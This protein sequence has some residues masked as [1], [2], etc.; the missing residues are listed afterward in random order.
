M[1]TFSDGSK[2]PV[3]NAIKAADVLYKKYFKF[4]NSAIYQQ[5]ASIAQAT[6]N[7]SSDEEEGGIDRMFWDVGMKNFSNFFVH[8]AMVQPHSLQ[9]TNEVLKERQQLESTIISHLSMKG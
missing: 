5:S 6:T 9:L 4:N 7:D 3:V 2:P 1:I 8:F